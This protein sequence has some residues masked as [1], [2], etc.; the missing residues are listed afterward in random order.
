MWKTALDSGHLDA[1][2][3]WAEIR[4]DQTK[5]PN[6]AFLNQVMGWSHDDLEAII[7]VTVGSHGEVY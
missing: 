6:Q 7:L 3:Y 1:F 5:A 4:S 2:Q